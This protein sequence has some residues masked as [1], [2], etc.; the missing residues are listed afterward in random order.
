VQPASYDPLLDLV[1]A[2]QLREILASLSSSTEAV[3][4]A[5]APHDSYFPA[6]AST[7]RGAAVG[8]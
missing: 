7:E 4:S 8:T 3:A 2:A 5:A 1:S 6:R